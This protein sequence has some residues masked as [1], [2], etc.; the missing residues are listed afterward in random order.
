MALSCIISELERDIGQKARFF[1][2]PAGPPFVV[3]S[4]R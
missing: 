1:I 2:P 3:A 4:R